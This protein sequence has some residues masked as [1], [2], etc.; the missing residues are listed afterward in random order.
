M[1]IK[2]LLCL[3]ALLPFHTLAERLIEN[4][5]VEVIYFFS[6]HCSGCF[7]TKDY[8]NLW[9]KTSGTKVRRVPVFNDKQWH[10]GAKL[11]ASTSLLKKAYNINQSQFDR[12]NFSIIQSLNGRD[13]DRDLFLA[14]LSTAGYPGTLSEINA[15]W[16]ESES[17][18]VAATELLKHVSNEK[19]ISTPSARIS[20]GEKH[21]W[22]S[23][24]VRHENPGMAFL[25]EI[26]AVSKELR[27]AS[28]N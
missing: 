17:L 1:K 4:E 24:D 11:F 14:S 27:R 5:G 2:I 19:E 20:N 21:V 22:V 26:N 3:L 18:I 28:S 12:V 13:L 9:E 25:S 15:A 10:A 23:L 16:T 6:Y 7:A 8:I